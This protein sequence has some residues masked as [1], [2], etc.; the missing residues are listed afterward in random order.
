[1]DLLS[2]QLLREINEEISHEEGA[3]N[4]I[5]EIEIRYVMTAGIREGSSLVWAFD[6]ENLYYKNSYSDSTGVRACKCYFNGCSARLYIRPNG[7][8]FRFSDIKHADFHGSMYS[9]YKYAYCFNAMKQ[10]AKSALAST[11]THDI[12]KEVVLE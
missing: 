7:T 3:I 2:A 6:E 9:T 4:T 1:M 5:G 11:T 12:Y 10:K 8:A